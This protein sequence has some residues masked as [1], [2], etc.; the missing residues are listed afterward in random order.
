V[1]M[2]A[3][4]TVVDMEEDMVVDMA[5]GSNLVCYMGEDTAADMEEDM[6]VDMAAGNTVVDMEEDMVVDMAVDMVRDTLL[7]GISVDRDMGTAGNMVEVDTGN[8]EDRVCRVQ[9]RGYSVVDKDRK[10]HIELSK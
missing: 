2:A 6:V 8:T 4:N 9:H 7:G 3:D 1:D 5:E 10:D